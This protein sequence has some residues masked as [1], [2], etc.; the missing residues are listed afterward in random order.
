MV[1]E[2][3]SGDRE[4]QNR[5][6]TAVYDEMRR[7][8]GRSRFVGAEGETLQ[9]TALAN[10]AYVLLSQQFAIAR[11]TDASAREALCVTVD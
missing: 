4:A 1:E 7:I 8:A 10:E 2:A 3:S 9:P 11:I 6:F 5:L